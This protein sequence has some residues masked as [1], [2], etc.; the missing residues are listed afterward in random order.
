MLT[1]AAPSDNLGDLSIEK[2][3]TFDALTSAPADR[4]IPLVTQTLLHEIFKNGIRF[5]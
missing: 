4:L 3:I 5:A 2:N 1:E